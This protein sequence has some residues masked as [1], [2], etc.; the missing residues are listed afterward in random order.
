MPILTD[1]SKNIL[2]RALC[3]RSPALPA[4]IFLA[5]GSGGGTAGLTGEP[6]GNGYARQR[7]TFTGTGQQRNVETVRFVFSAAAGNLTHV[8]LYDAATGGNGLAYG[9]LAATAAVSGP[10]TVTVPAEAVTITGS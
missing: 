10:G 7:V 6:V 2:A 8:G 1:Y 5:L 4:T 9:L 3:G